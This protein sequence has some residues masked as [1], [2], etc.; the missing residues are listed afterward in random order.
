MRNLGGCY[1]RSPMEVPGRKPCPRDESPLEHPVHSFYLLICCSLSLTEGDSESSQTPFQSSC[2]VTPRVETLWPISCMNLTTDQL[3][4][5]KK[6]YWRLGIYGS[7]LSPD[8]LCDKM[9]LVFYASYMTL[10]EEVGEWDSTCVYLLVAL[11]AEMKGKRFKRTGM[12]QVWKS[13]L[14]QNYNHGKHDRERHSATESQLNMS[15]IYIA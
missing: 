6:G 15:T 3:S 13:K 9:M 7:K 12:L 4:L 8:K 14:L 1:I 5:G 10:E 2:H 11:V